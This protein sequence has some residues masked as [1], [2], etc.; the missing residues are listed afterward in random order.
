MTVVTVLVRSRSETTRKK[1]SSGAFS[2]L[3][4]PPGRRTPDRCDVKTQQAIHKAPTPGAVL[5]L[6]RWN[7]WVRVLDPATDE[8]QWVFLGET[9]YERVEAESTG[10]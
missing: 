9:E 8:T 7:S 10:A 6:Q 5:V 3:S 4:A 1:R 2:A